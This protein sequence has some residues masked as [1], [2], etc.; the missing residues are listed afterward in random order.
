M[1]K[2]SVISIA[3]TEK[4][5][6]NLRGV[7]AKQ[8][9]RDFEFLVSTGG[10]IPEAWNS[11]ISKA[12]GDYIILIESDAMPLN[13]TWLEEISRIVKKRT[14]YKGLE[15][16]PTDLD[17]CNFVCDA[18]ILKQEKFDSSFTV[19]EDMELFARLRSKRVA[20]R[21]VMGFP[22]IHSP[23]QTWEKTLSRSLKR[24]VYYARIF[25][26]YGRE[27]VDDIN[28]RNLQRNYINPV[29][30]RMRMITENVLVLL[31]ELFGLIFCLPILI[32]RRINRSK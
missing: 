24:G 31:G 30:N 23:S 20:I 25:Y 5:L 18:S 17:L 11:A 7:L 14:A 22:V 26:L 12:T 19:C 15:I 16:N 8:T 29:S 1:P 21:N 2:F 13:S 27:N 10:T 28:T 32:K 9:F 6:E 4:E 3:K